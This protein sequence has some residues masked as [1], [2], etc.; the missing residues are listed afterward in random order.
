MSVGCFSDQGLDSWQ[1]VG[2]TVN[3]RK[4]VLLKKSKTNKRLHTIFL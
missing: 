3:E 2:A 4:I 1:V